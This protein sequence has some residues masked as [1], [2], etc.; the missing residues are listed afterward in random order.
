MHLLGGEVR[1]R[2]RRRIV[3][4]FVVVLLAL[5]LGWVVTG[6]F[7]IVQPSLQRATHVGAIVV[8][9]PSL[10]DRLAEAVDIAHR[11]EISDLA[12]SVGDTPGQITG[13]YCAEP[14]P[15]IKVTCFVPTPYTTRGEAREIGRLAAEH[16]WSS[17]IVIAP[18]PQ[19][20]RARY[21]VKR[22][23]HGSV[24]MLASP[25]RFSFSEWVWQFFYQ[26]A[27]FAKAVLQSGC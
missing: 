27:A 1:T 8:L 2:P 19:V 9:G 4:R 23:Y 12:I 7:V 5:L 21:L 10:N 16:S 17:V 25:D 18:K 11:Y 15:G 22:C 24:E 14:P 13:G 20:S 6:Y 26:S 3:L